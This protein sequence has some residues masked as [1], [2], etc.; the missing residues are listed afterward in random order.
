M[1]F[2]LT[3]HENLDRGTILARAAAVAGGQAGGALATIHAEDGT[4]YVT[5][6]L[7]HLCE[8]G[9]LLFG[10]RFNEGRQPQH[11]RNMVATPEVSF[12]IDNRATPPEKW[13]NFVRIVIEGSAEIELPAS[14][15]YAAH[16]AALRTKSPLAASFAEEGELTRIIPRRLILMEGFSAQ[17]HVVEFAEA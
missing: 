5:Y 10:S 4:P 1:A 13:D 8:D 9:T 12:L 11:N 15:D 17:R 3:D 16:L 6:V 2:P 14:P 7:F